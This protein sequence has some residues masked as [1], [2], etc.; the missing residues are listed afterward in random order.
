M[1]IPMMEED[2]EVIS[3][4]GDTP[5]NDD[6]LT[7]QQLKGRFDLAGVRIKNFLNTVLIPQLNQLVDVQALLNGILDSTLSKPDK[8]A[9]A[10]A[11]GDKISQ[12]QQTANAALPKSGGSMSGVLNMNNQ[13]LTGLPVPT[14]GSQAVPKNYVDTTLN[15]VI[16]TTAGWEG[17]EAPYTQSVEIT[18]LDDNKIARAYPMYDQDYER[19]LE[20]MRDSSCI[21]YAMQ[22]GGSITFYCLV[23]KPEADV[24]VIVEVGV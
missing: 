19:N 4:L 24:S 2:V 1:A 13:Q 17:T 6:G 5:G 15:P 22:D 16:L 18:G 9:N 23:S 7:A 3:K 10:K 21:S 20:L 14:G 11:T 8:A 12:V